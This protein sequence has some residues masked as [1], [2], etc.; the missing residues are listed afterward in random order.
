[1]DR[2][3]VKHGMT[4]QK[5]REKQMKKILFA[6]TCMFLASPSFAYKTLDDLTLLGGFCHISGD[7]KDSS[8]GNCLSETLKSLKPGMWGLPMLD[9]KD[10]LDLVG[11][12]A[13]VDY[14]G[15][16]E[17]GEAADNQSYFTKPDGGPYCYCQMTGPETS[18][19]MYVAASGDYEKCNAICARDCATWIETDESKI[20][21]N[22]FKTVN[23]GGGSSGGDD[24]SWL[25]DTTGAG[26]RCFVGP[27]GKFAN[28][29]CPS[30]TD[31]I[32]TEPRQWAAVLDS[33]EHPETIVTGTAWVSN[34]IDTK[35]PYIGYIPTT[36][37]GVIQQIND[38]YASYKSGEDP[39][40][41]YCYCKME[42]PAES[43]WVLLYYEGMDLGNCIGECANNTSKR[44]QTPDST[45]L[46]NAM[47][48]TLKSAA[49]GMSMIVTTKKYVDGLLNT[50]QARITT[51]G[52]DRLMTFGSSAG[53][54]GIRNIVS[55]LGTSTTAT[56]V[57][58]VGPIVAGIN[59]KQ[60]A[61][62][63]T[64]N[65]V[66][67]RTGT[68]GIM[69]S[70]PV[71][72]ATNNYSNA[73]ITA[74]TINTAAATA[75]NGELYCARF[76]DGAPQTDANCL[77][78]GMNTTAPAGMDVSRFWVA[79]PT[80]DGTSQCYRGL[81]GSYDNNGTCGADT[82]S[83]LGVVWNKSGKWGT[84]FPYGDISGISVC[85]AVSASGAG[86][87]ATD[88][89]AATLDS[90]YSA[91]AG[92]GE[93]ALSGSLTYCWCKMENPAASSWVY[94]GRTNQVYSFS[95]ATGCAWACSSAAV[96]LRSAM[97]GS[98][99]Q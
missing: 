16:Q 50:K 49:G 95:C 78:W 68:A 27:D 56:S 48:S 97:F 96:S 7:E 25:Y 9:G 85:S 31:K 86:T 94:S 98:A 5:K 24:Y 30:G 73:L 88:A 71:Y 84:V 15:K 14:R 57:P 45:T 55:A 53:N 83:Y 59:S 80:I 82:L 43:S 12:S 1:M 37:P 51:I 72:S 41:K 69:N 61:V 77:L 22:M 99:T 13:C 74:Q 23:Y 90:E 32:I 47:F 65:N 92:V 44:G 21:T 19:W 42:T 70:K 39:Y 8:T 3:R 2:F 28:E 64:A 10:Q 66:M 54:I 75:A 26:G 17:K 76:V 46:T 52:T 67:T 60:N 18:A 79:D 4:K 93:S 11:I 58:T 63:G 38:E 34:A 35:D 91:Q 81:N 40:G 6:V 29:G 62:N 36:D 89:Q 20:R 33:K 87:I